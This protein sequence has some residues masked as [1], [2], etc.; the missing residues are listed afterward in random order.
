MTRAL[1][2]MYEQERMRMHQAFM[3]L[4]AQVVADVARLLVSAPV[5]IEPFTED[6]LEESEDPEE[7]EEEPAEQNATLDDDVAMVQLSLHQPPKPDAFGGPG[8]QAG[9]DGNFGSRIP[10]ACTTSADEAPSRTASRRK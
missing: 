2:T 5:Q 7:L 3:T 8:R 10:R 9:G 6:E 1:E 4:I